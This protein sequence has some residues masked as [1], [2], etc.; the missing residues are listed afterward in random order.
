M[1]LLDKEAPQLEAMWALLNEAVAR[2]VIQ[3]PCARRGTPSRVNHGLW[4]APR[5]FWLRAWARP[6]G[7]IAEAEKTLTLGERIRHQGGYRYFRREEIILAGVRMLRRAIERGD[8]VPEAT[9]T[10]LQRQVQRLAGQVLEDLRAVPVFFRIFWAQYADPNPHRWYGRGDYEYL[11]P[12]GAALLYR[13]FVRA[14][15]ELDLAERRLATEAGARIVA[16]RDGKIPAWNSQVPSLSGV[17]GDALELLTRLRLA[18]LALT[19]DG[20]CPPEAQRPLDALTGHPFVC[21]VTRDVVFVAVPWRN[22]DF[23]LR[24]VWTRDIWE[25]TPRDPYPDWAED[26]MRDDGWIW[27]VPRSR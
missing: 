17:A 13:D 26:P 1:Q 18:D 5:L 11:G 6:E 19:V 7:Q 16:A 10:R 27:A 25:E 22:L 21:R 20:D 15:D 2:R 4:V 8:E 12:D 9:R 3:A 24:P 14:Y 23:P